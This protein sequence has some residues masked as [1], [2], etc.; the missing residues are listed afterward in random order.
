MYL[1][2][3]SP[4]GVMLSLMTLLHVVHTATD[5]V[6]IVQTFG[7]VI[8][9]FWEGRQGRASYEETKHDVS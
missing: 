1:Q 3:G 7:M 6:L 8:L 2:H 9:I 4:H 5:A